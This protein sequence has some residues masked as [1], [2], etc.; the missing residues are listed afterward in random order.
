MIQT[1][2]FFFLA[3]FIL[4]AFLAVAQTESNLFVTKTEAQY[5]KSSCRYSQTGREATLFEAKDRRI[6]AYLG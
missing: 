6:T 1:I 4:G 2:R 3:V 5:H